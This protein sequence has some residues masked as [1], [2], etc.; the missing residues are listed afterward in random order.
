MRMKSPQNA[1]SWLNTMK[2]WLADNW[3]EQPV[4]AVCK[5]GDPG[6]VYCKGQP[7]CGRWPDLMQRC[8]YGLVVGTGSVRHGFAP[9]LLRVPNYTSAY[10]PHVPLP[11]RRAA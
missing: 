5:S 6:E 10:A 11:V 8:S 1:N 3:L 4:N 9:P 7:N 2:S